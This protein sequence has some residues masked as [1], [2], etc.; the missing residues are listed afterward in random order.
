MSGGGEKMR[1]PP[2]VPQASRQLELF[3]TFYGDDDYSNT[4]EVWDSIPRHSV[5]PR[6]QNAMRDENGRLPVH[7]HRY[8]FKE[9]I[10]RMEV[11]PA[12]IKDKDGKRRDYYPS[13]DEELVEE[14]LRKFF[15]EEHF[16]LHDE[17]RTESWVRFTLGMVRRELKKRGRTRSIDQIKRSLDIMALASVRLNEGES[18]HPAYTASILSD[19]VRVTRQ[20]YLEDGKVMWAA[21]LPALI[22]RSL[23]DHT[24][25]QFNYRV[26]MSLDA[27][28]ARWLHKRLCRRFDYAGM[29]KKH[30]L[31]FRSMQRDSGLL[32]AN[33]DAK[34]LA[35]VEEALDALVAA[36][37]LSHWTKEERRG[38]RRQL[39]DVV[40]D[41]HAS[42][43][44]SS[45]QRTANK[46]S[47]DALDELRGTQRPAI[48]SG[49]R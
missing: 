30:N 23:A 7:E 38:E 39:D 12:L 15:A 32:T 36:D 14:V 24:Y 21:R 18:E 5:T 4:A 46:R 19:V 2:A 37:V 42:F 8:K 44:F 41:L 49:R 28:F 6:R 1:Q 45:E 22:S 11:L 25:R 29:G 27:Q 16:G 10:W 17:R 43:T 35:T 48:P 40:Y 33:R 13:A 47:R 31:S 20:Q 34:N 3:Q 26:L 9:K